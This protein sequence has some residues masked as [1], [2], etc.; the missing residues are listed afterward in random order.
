M[1]CRDYISSKAKG[2]PVRAGIFPDSF[3]QACLSPGQQQTL[4]SIR[5]LPCRGSFIAAKAGNIGGRAGQAAGSDSCS[6]VPLCHL[7]RGRPAG[8]SPLRSG[9]EFGWRLQLLMLHALQL[10]P[11]AQ[12]RRERVVKQHLQDMAMSLK[13]PKEPHTSLLSLLKKAI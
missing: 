9:A 2:S 5:E 12:V 1:L 13:S 6:I 4:L 7:T 10:L 11:S 8:T 3:G